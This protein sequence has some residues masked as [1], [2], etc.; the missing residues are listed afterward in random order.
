MT[1]GDKIKRLRRVND[2]SQQEL[3]NYLEINRNHLSRIETNKSEPTS[4]IILKLTTLF[5]I[6]ANTLLGS[7]NNQS[8]REEKIKYINDHCTNLTDDDL[9]FM[10]RIIN[11]MKEE[12]LKRD[13]IK[14][15]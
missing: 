15:K 14:N 12:Y 5:E 10:I 11:V 7:N 2:M 6:S 13:F 1:L 4:T 9:D 3:A 8:Q